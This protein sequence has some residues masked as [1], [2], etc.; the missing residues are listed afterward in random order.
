MKTDKKITQHDQIIALLDLIKEERR[1]R[2]P[3][4]ILDR[5]EEER[6]RMKWNDLFECVRLYS[7]G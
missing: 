6:G 2:T 7:H 5:L 4:E 3:Q 1:Y